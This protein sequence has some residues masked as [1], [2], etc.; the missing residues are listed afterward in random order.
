MASRGA[1]LAGRFEPFDPDEDEIY[2]GQ[3]MG[4]RGMKIAGVLL[5]AAVL[6][7][8]CGASVSTKAMDTKFAKVD[9]DMA[10][11]EDGKTPGVHLERLTR[12]YIALIHEYEDQLGTDEVKRRLAQKAAALSPYCLSCTTMLDD[13]RK[14]YY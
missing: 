4:T 3:T 10:S 11:V 8:G 2:I 12:Q 1:E 14:K 5:L 6:L 7:A 13:E 9:Y